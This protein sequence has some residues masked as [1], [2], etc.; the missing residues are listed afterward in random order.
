MKLLRKIISFNTG[1][2]LIFYEFITEFQESEILRDRTD[3]FKVI[4][5]GH[6]LWG[7]LNE[8]EPFQ[9][10]GQL[11]GYDEREVRKFQLTR[12]E[13]FACIA[14]ELGH[15]YDSTPKDRHSERECNADQMAKQLGLTE[16]L[17]SAISKLTKDDEHG[18]QSL[19]Q[20]RIERIKN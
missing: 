17:I 2:P 6:S 10:N 5:P 13:C 8:G 12:E 15:C 1:A 9:C 7:F 14:H 11:I 18:I 16:G 4:T 19:T 3:L 20:Q